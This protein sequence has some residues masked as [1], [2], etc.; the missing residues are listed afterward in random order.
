VMTTRVQPPRDIERD[1]DIFK[2]INRVNQQNLGVYA[3]V[4]QPGTVRLGDAV[5]VQAD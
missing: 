1:L 2:T 5:L 4:T 3:N